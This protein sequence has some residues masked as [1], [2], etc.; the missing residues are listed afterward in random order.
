MIN[1]PNA[2]ESG[3]YRVLIVDDMEAN[4]AVMCRRLERYGYSIE[5]AASGAA[6]LQA[7]AKSMPD[8]VLLDYMM[9]QMNGIE[10]LRELRGN[11]A[12]RELPVIMVTARAES[13]ATVEALKEG[14]DDYVTKPIDFDVLRAR[15]DAHFAKR[16][17]SADLQRAN[18][19]LDERVTLRSMSLADMEVELQQE[20][21]RRREL[22]RQIRETNG[23]APRQATPG[24]LD[25]VAEAVDQIAAKYEIVFGN[26][27]AGRT[28]NFAQMAE[29]RLMIDQLKQAL[30]AGSA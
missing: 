4:R 21:D 26:A 29:L 6:A 3:S 1:Q 11:A 27:T 22:E 15:M 2:A 7:I 30:R 25:H 8:I 5:T 13:D 17:D 10:V 19:A 20:T 9:P 16:R 14:V 28:P 18:A 12:T 23:D 24:M